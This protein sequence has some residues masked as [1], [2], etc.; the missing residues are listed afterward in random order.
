[1]NLSQL[2]FFPW[3]PELL[4]VGYWKSWSGLR[5]WDLK[6]T[7]EDFSMNP[8]FLTPL[9]LK[10][11]IGL[12]GSPVSWILFGNEPELLRFVHRVKPG[13][14]GLPNFPQINLNPGSSF[15]R[16]MPRRSPFEFLQVNWNGAGFYIFTVQEL[17]EPDLLDLCQTLRA[18]LLMK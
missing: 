2:Y 10:P 1:M 3:L 17:L 4:A 5:A 15:W 14:S 12:L 8:R 7:C 18:D 9:A 13:D 16:P 6:I 11:Q